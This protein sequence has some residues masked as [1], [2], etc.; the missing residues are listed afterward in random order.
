MSNMS[1][2]NRQWITWSLGILLSFGMTVGGFVV[3][4]MS[5]RIDK[6]ENQLYALRTDAASK[7]AMAQSQAEMIRYIDTKF[8]IVESAQQ[9][10]AR[11]LN[12]LVEDNKSFQKEL[13]SQFNKR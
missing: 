6:V 13:R 2:N 3:T 12:I 4:S 8:Q 11:Q 10:T 1:E 9:E 7:A 5:S